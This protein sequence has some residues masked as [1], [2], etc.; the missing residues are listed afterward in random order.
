MA[1]IHAKCILESEIE[2]V[3]EFIEN[4]RMLNNYT[5]IETECHTNILVIYCSDK[6]WGELCNI[7]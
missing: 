7:L 3:F 5:L 6:D 2:K 1:K 4:K